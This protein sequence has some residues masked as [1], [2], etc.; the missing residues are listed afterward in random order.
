MSIQIGT[1]NY[2]QANNNTKVKK[3]YFKLVNGDNFYRI[4]PPCFE[5]AEAGTWSK[6]Y[7]IHFGYKSSPNEKGLSMHKPFVCPLRKNRN[8]QVVSSCAEHD[9]I[10]EAKATVDS[11]REELQSKGK[12]KEEIQ[13]ALEPLTDFLTEHNADNKYYVNAKSSDGSIGLLKLPYRAYKDLEE[14]IKTVRDRYKIDPIA[15]DGGVWFNIKRSGTKFNEIAYKVE[16]QMVMVDTPMGKAEV[17]KDAKLT[18]ADFENMEIYAFDLSNMYP[19]LTAEQV[20]ML[21][22]TMGDPE[23]VDQIFSQPEKSSSKEESK[24]ETPSTEDFKRRFA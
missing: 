16:I 24:S 20:K 2:N 1:P 11:K 17:L 3:N 5:L 9:K 19:V 7:S 21:V 4:L 23:V 8:G 15:A 12:S 14:T 18:S 10:N 13:T 6:Y 22:D